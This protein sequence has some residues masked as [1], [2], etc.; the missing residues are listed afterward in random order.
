LDH[1]HRVTIETIYDIPFFK[2]NSH[3]IEKNLIGN[4]EVAPIYTFQSS[5]YLTPQSSVD[6]NLNGD[7]VPDR[8][9]RNPNGVRGTGSAVTPLTNSAK[10]VVAYQAVNPNA[11]YIE[12]GLV[13]L[14][15]TTEILIR[16]RTLTISISLP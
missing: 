4:W 16:C 10:Q 8:T 5:Q 7:S 6:S 3:W 13:L 11:E 15:R 2:T 14:R 9:I 12:A 1:R